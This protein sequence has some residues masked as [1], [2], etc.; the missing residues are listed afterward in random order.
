MPLGVGM[1]FFLYKEL[2]TVQYLKNNH[3]REWLL[4]YYENYVRY[5]TPTERADIELLHKQR[6]R[7]K[8]MLSAKSYLS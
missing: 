6:W 8:A 2:C 7:K 4:W 3:Q 5:S 1:F